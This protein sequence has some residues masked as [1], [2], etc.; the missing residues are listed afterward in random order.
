[1]KVKAVGTVLCFNFSEEKYKALEAICRK[2]GHRIKVIV[3]SDWGYPLGQLAGFAPKSSVGEEAAEEHA[4]SDELMVLYN[5]P[6]TTLDKLLNACRINKLDIPYKAIL[7]ATNADWY[8][9]AMAEQM[10]KEAKTMNRSR[11]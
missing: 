8:P 10:K 3:P 11:N 2:Q 4:F 5:F 7:T 9:D 1:M 6:G